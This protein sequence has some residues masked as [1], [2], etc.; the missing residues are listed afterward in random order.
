M[1]VMKLPRF[2]IK[3]LFL[4]TTLIAIGTAMAVFAFFKRQPDDTIDHQRLQAGAFSTAFI[5]AGIA[6]LLT[7]R[8]WLGAALGP[9]AFLMAGIVYALVSQWSEE[10]RST[11]V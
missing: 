5:G 3:Q 4:C 6:T 2:T 11:Q 10:G 8:V 7:N 1:T 9:L